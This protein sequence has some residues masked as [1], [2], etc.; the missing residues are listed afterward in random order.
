[1]GYSVGGIHFFPDGKKYIFHVVYDVDSIT[2]IREFSSNKL[3]RTLTFTKDSDDLNTK[4]MTFSPDGKFIIYAGEH[5]KGE[6]FGRGVRI[7]KI[8][9]EE[10]IASYYVDDMDKY[11]FSSLDISRDGNLI[12]LSGWTESSP[13]ERRCLSV[14]DF[15]KRK[16]EFEKEKQVIQEKMRAR[17]KY[18]KEQKEFLLNEF[19]NQSRTI[20]ALIQE[21]NYSKAIELLSKY[22][23][24]AKGYD[25]Y[26]IMNWSDEKLKACKVQVIK[27]TVLN[28]CTKY[29]RLQII[30]IAEECGVNNQLIISTV[31]AMIKNQE[32]YAKYF[33]SSKSVAFDQQANIEEI[34]NLMTAY[35]KW[36]DKEFGKK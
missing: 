34:D 28:L 11:L 18:E 25:L 24:Q 19:E 13:Y 35:K 1:V 14:W 3:L 20:E 4:L 8:E 23:K 30:E 2:E 26:E 15:S 27:K 29:A 6:K 12:A 31:K 5:K 9:T 10:L 36:E 33:E 17:I 16:A 7:R 21:S 32:I 22:R